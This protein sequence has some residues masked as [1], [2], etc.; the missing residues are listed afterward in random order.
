MFKLAFVGTSGHAWSAFEHVHENLEPRAEVVGYCKGYAEEDPSVLEMWAGELLYPRLKQYDDL[1]TM[2]DETEPDVL[3]VDGRC[4]EHAAMSREALSRSISVYCD[5]PLA[6]DE[7]ELL[8]LY[9][10]ADEHHAV[11]WSMQSLRFELPMYT[12][13]RLATEKKIGRL[14]MISLQKSYQLGRRPAWHKERALYG[15][16]I[17]RVGIQGIDLLRYFSD[18]AFRKVSALTSS[19]H[20]KGCGDFQ[21]MALMNFEME[22]DILAE[23][24][25]DFYRPA[26][27]ES[28]SD[29]YVRLVG[30]EGTIEVKD[31]KVRLFN[32]ECRNEEQPL[33]AA[34]LHVFT[35]FLFT[36]EAKKN[37]YASFNFIPE[38]TRRTM[39]AGLSNDECRILAQVSLRADRAAESRETIDLDDIFAAEREEKEARRQEAEA[40][41]LAAMEEEAQLLRRRKRLEEAKAKR[42]AAVKEANCPS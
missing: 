16:L 11:Y 10:L 1:K 30:T 23:L 17:P 3:V 12:A 26:S 36:L 22:D 6:L 14:R 5:K 27:A 41:A 32:A 24:R 40:E 21:T 7:E 38:R 39:D 19:A 34:P 37:P 31:G 35:A 15:S 18:A 29:T 2:L 8:E 25:V 4:G 28:V 13:K 9:R 33:T 42:A 20:N